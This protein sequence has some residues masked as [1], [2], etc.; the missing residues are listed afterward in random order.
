MYQERENWMIDPRGIH[1]IYRLAQG[2]A[3]TPAE[4][5][6]ARATMYLIQQIVVPARDWDK[7]TWS[8]EEY[9]M[10]HTWPLVNER[11]EIENGQFA[12]G[13]VKP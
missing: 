11:F 10:R 9:F 5:E 1:L 7:F 4:E 6:S 13:A 2:E 12:H 8:G 3:L